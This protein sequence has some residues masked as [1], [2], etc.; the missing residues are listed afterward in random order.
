[1]T[2]KFDITGMLM[3]NPCD[4]CQETGCDP[5]VCRCECHLIGDDAPTKEGE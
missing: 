1:M 4:S 2:S 3:T 5:E